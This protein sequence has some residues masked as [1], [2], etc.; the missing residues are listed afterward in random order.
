MT[1]EL[2][3][4]GERSAGLDLLRILSMLLVVVLHILGRGGA[5]ENARPFTANYELA[6]LLET[7]A[8]CAVDCYA[9]LSGYLLC[10]S[11]CRSGSLIGLWFQVFVYSAGITLAFAVF[12]EH[13]SLGRF[14]KSCLPVSF[15][16]YWY[17]TAYF[18][19]YCIA[20]FLNR[21][22][23]SL[24]REAF[25]RLEWTLFLLL[26]LVPTLLGQDPF[27]TGKGYSFLWLSALYVFGSGERLW[28][29][30]RTRRAGFWFGGY[31]LCVLAVFFSRL[32]IETVTQARTGAPAGGGWLLTYT[33]P[34][35]LGAAL[36]LF[37]AC[38][39]LQIRNRAARGLIGF[40]APVSFGV[41][42]IHAQ[43]FIF[44]RLLNGAF[45]PLLAA[46]PGKFTAG[47]LGGAAAI[48]LVCALADW[49]RLTVFRLL[50]ILKLA[51]AL[52]ERLDRRLPP[53]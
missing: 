42:L 32:A 15:G 9:V 2:K 36:C 40:F 39:A 3:K 17:F 16:Q 29:P 14:L 12:R 35:I 53:L 31:A 43:P 20:P 52:G 26:S 30:E 41:Y 18:A 46:G 13:V 48:F 10:R 37:R 45:A 6:W 22:L 47:V 44:H 4:A 19:V 21:L 27:V 7:A 51:E 34:L 38:L 24:N 5:L 50:R 23:V 1:E 8:Y 28:P 33:S 25:R 49:V 11:R